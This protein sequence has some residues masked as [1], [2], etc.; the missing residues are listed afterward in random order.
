MSM[1]GVR[2][3]L[4]LAELHCHLE[5][6]VPPDL[7]LKLGARHGRDLSELIGPDGAWVWTSFLDFLRVYDAMSEVI[8]TPLDHYDVAKT[9]LENGAALGL[10]YGE[11]FVSPA[12]AERHGISYPDLIGGVAAAMQETER[13][14]GVHGRIILTC[15]RHYGVEHA[16]ATA[17]LA[18]QHPHP[19]V[20]GFGMAGE[21]AFGSARDYARAF[22]IAR[23]AGLRTTA[24]AGEIMG[25]ESVRDT[26]DHLYVDRIGHGI[27]SL[28][29]PALV[30]ELVRRRIPLEICPGSN[31][32]MKLFDSLRVHPVR[33]YF[34]AG[35]VVTL[36]TDDPA[37]FHTDIRQ[38][39]EGAARV[40]GFTEAELL[41]ITENSFHAA[42]CG[43]VLKA[44]LLE[45]LAEWQFGG[46][47]GV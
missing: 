20:V 10:R 43:D 42:F 36:S 45:E 33:R 40:H 5:G 31:I 6:T 11:I 22:A 13:T 8:Q 19:Y 18:E 29:S 1:N 32:A 37:F 41:R 44:R 25:P 7:A 14:C 28:E 17:R 26:L 24:H 38:E 47:N 15:V 12:H 2:A 23:G 3:G 34:D 9:Y 16:E 30:D 27:R 39:Y 46:G 4:P 21:E 35:A